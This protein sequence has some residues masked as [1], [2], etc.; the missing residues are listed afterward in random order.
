M[1]PPAMPGSWMHDL[2]ITVARPVRR[3][4]GNAVPRCDGGGGSIYCPKAVVDCHSLIR[5]AFHQ[6][7]LRVVHVH[8][9]TCAFW[10]GIKAA[11]YSDPDPK[12]CLFS[13]NCRREGSRGW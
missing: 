5:P 10:P 1:S 9:E 11:V 2:W 4:R 12:F 8:L 6:P 7:S 13:R 3:R